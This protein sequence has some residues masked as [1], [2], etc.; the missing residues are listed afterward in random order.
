VASRRARI[1][2]LESAAL[3][4]DRLVHVLEKQGE[5]KLA[6]EGQLYRSELLKRALNIERAPKGK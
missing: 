3:A 5:L 6:R 4:M 1:A 2:K